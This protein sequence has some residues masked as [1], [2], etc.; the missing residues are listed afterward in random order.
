MQLFRTP[1]EIPVSEFNL[2]Y[3]KNIT[4]IGSCF[5]DNIGKKL[6]HYKFPVSINPFGVLY[7]PDSVRNALDI[8]VNEKYFGEE[9]LYEHNSRWLSF[10]HD[11]SFSG[12]D[13]EMVL[14]E[15]NKSIHSGN[16]WLN[17]TNLLI[18]T[19]GTARVYHHKKRDHIVSNC[20]KVPAKEFNRYLLDINEIVDGYRELIGQLKKFN[21]KLHI[22]FTI[23]PVRHWKDGAVGNQQS[24]AILV[25]AIKKLLGEFPELEYFPAYEILMDELRNYR[26][27]AEDMLHPGETGINYIWDRFCETYI[28]KSTWKLMEKVD[29]IVKA[30]NHRP[31]HPKSLEYQEFLKKQI[32]KTEQFLDKYPHIDLRPELD[33]FIAQL[34]G[35]EK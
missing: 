18:I 26:F 32:E 2:T 6:T 30:K 4:M 21:P 12:H 13:R 23:S 24:K 11:T 35:I 7:N 20:H 14:Q 8:L 16:Q 34:E 10:Y 31:F 19:F 22:V 25:L 15:I 9:D 28:K 29:A 1:I 5:T 3:K 27:Y 17:K 33:Y